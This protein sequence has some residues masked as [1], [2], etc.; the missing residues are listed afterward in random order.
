[1][2]LSVGFSNNFPTAVNLKE[3]ATDSQLLRVTLNGQSVLA[4]DWLG[5]SDVIA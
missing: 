3:Y 1:L 2:Q 4:P 5:N